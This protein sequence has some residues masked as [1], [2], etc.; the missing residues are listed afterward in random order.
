MPKKFVTGDDAQTNA[1]S[2]KAR[3]CVMSKVVRAWN[4]IRVKLLWLAGSANC[5]R[6]QCGAMGG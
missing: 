2:G 3:E 5:Q 4:A 1:W 6:T